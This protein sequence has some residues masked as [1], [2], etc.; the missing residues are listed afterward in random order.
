MDSRRACARCRF[1]LLLLLL[2]LLS[3][4]QPD[5]PPPQ[6]PAPEINCD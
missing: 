4:L 1:T 2:L 6:L 3:L 5:E